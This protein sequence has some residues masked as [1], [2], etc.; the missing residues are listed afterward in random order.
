MILFLFV[1]LLMHQHSLDY[2]MC[3]KH[4]GIGFMV[5]TFSQWQWIYNE[6]YGWNHLVP[7]QTK[8]ERPWWRQQME[9]LSVT[10]LLGQWRQALEF[11]LI[12]AQINGWVNNGEAGDLGHNHAHYDV[13]VKGVYSLGLTLPH[14]EH[15][16]ELI[17]ATLEWGFYFTAS[18]IS[19]WLG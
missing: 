11:S 18:I 4:H 12:C 15:I 8:T 10:G 9:T 16:N 13:I 1:L 3:T 6:R 19:G 2:V 14:R 7:T 17:Q 5:T